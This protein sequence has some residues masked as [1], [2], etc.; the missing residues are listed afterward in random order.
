MNLR[1]ID[2]LIHYL[3]STTM[4]KPIE[5]TLQLTSS[6]AWALAE[7]AK[8]IGYTEIRAQ[9]ANET[10]AHHMNNGLYK[11]AGA[12]AVAGVAPR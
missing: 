9:A 6:E 7:L 5:V 10:E 11:L 3:L 12:L 8:R 4:E 2:A 1:D